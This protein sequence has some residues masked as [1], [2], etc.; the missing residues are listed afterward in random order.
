MR[1][2]EAGF[3][4]IEMLIVMAVIGI[5]VG[6][7]LS[8]NGATA[9][10]AGGGE[11]ALDEVERRLYE[12]HDAA[13]RLNRLAAPT[14]LE[15]YTAPPVEIDLTNATTTRALLIE[16]VDANGDGRDDNTGSTLTSLAPPATAGGQGTWNYSY[17]NS[18][19]LAL[20]IGWRILTAPEQLGA[21]PQIGLGQQGRG[22]LA[23]GFGFDGQGRAMV[24][25]AAGVWTTLPVGS[26]ATA[27]SPQTAPFWAVYM[28]QTQG[29]ANNTAG[30][31]A[32]AVAISVHP[33]GQF[34]RWRW[35]GTTWRGF[36]RRTLP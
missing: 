32:A 36:R 21:I 30:V 9:S 17:E 7:A 1:S 13:V 31:G 14:S 2:R 18:Q 35:D 20:P 16:G 4:L 11:R 10:T 22:V 26:L 15:N 29:A 8:R 24:R 33:T 6:Y 5:L 34:E 23:T 12:R 3:S 19:A 27:D 25:N 28:V